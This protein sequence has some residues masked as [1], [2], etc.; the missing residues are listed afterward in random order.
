[1]GETVFMLTLFLCLYPPSRPELQLPGALLLSRLLPQHLKSS[2]TFL[3]VIALM[4]GVPVIEVLMCVGG[5]MYVC[6]CTTCMCY[7]TMYNVLSS[8]DMQEIVCSLLHM[9]LCDQV[10]CIILR[11]FFS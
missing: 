6:V 5:Y 1:M 9:A 7:N 4:L 11:N 8:M 10:P 3:L 2:Q